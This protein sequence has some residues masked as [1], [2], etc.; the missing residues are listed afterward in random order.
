MEDYT[1]HLQC[2]WGCNGEILATNRAKLQVSVMCSKCSKRNRSNFYIADLY[3]MKTRRAKSRDSRNFSHHVRC[4]CCGRGEITIDGRADVWISV[5]CNKCNEAFEA[6]LW[7]MKAY[8]SVK[9]R[10]KGRKK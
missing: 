2:P 10:R 7:N 1:I 9:I 8:P 4:P 6:D 3:A 5:I